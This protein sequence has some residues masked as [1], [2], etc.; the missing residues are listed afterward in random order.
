MSPPTNG[1][2]RSSP[3]STGTVPKSNSTMNGDRSRSTEPQ[4]N[5]SYQSTMRHQ[6]LERMLKEQQAKLRSLETQ[7][8]NNP[9]SLAE[10]LAE[11]S[12]KLRILQ[13]AK[14]NGGGASGDFGNRP[15]AHWPP[16]EEHCDDFD[17]VIGLEDENEELIK[18]VQNLRMRDLQNHIRML[19]SSSN[20]KPKNSAVEQQ[21]K[22]ENSK[23]K[24][25]YENQ[26]GQ[27][28]Q[29]TQ[30][31]NQCFQALLTIQR[32]VATLQQKI[33][34]QQQ[35]QHHH[36]STP[37]ET[38]VQ[39][40]HIVVEDNMDSVSQQRDFD[41]PSSWDFDF[42]RHH[43]S[44]STT[45]PSNNVDP[46][47]NYFAESR[48]MTAAATTGS[49]SGMSTG[50]LNNTVPPG[51]RANNYWDNFRSFSRQNRLQTSNLG[52]VGGLSPV[53]AQ[54]TPRQVQPTLHLPHSPIRNH[55]N[56]SNATH[57]SDPI[58]LDNSDPPYFSTGR[59]RRKQKINREHNVSG[60]QRPEAA[61]V[62]PMPQQ[63]VIT[64]F[65]F[66]K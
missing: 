7:Q 27:I 54:V 14:R 17:D 36:H 43:S 16:L 56:N 40:N 28:Q 31:L 25:A 11:L 33:D 4:A 22:A 5:A 1:R 23:L 30:S 44:E 8:Q 38:Q 39:N 59:P 26:Q 42:T 6:S 24:L 35:P 57:H 46:W 48:L 65:D 29:L 13:S 21:L 34:H 58:I 51:I 32:D 60:S 49:E 2:F 20:K 52:V 66:T 12:E 9:E 15:S 19:N 3:S 41:N 63:Q 62:F 10:N 18:A 55:T 53:V 47:N 64:Y 45:R 50:A 61:M 37:K